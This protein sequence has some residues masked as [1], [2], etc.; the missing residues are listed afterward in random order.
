MLLWSLRCSAQSTNNTICTPLPPPQGLVLDCAP[1]EFELLS[2]FPDPPA[3]G[4][5]SSGEVPIW[6]VLD[7]VMDP[8]S[9][10]A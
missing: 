3:G 2:S 4:R 7:E 10:S 1:L 6:L 5:G 8:V 9:H